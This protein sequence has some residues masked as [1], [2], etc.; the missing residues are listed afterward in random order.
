[1]KPKRSSR[2]KKSSPGPATS[3]MPRSQRAQ[4]DADSSDEEAEDASAIKQNT[5]TD[6]DEDELTAAPPPASSQ[7]VSSRLRRTVIVD[8]EDDEDGDSDDDQPIPT[9]SSRRQKV[10]PSEDKGGASDEDD[11]LPVAPSSVRRRRPEIV[12]L[13]SDSEDADISPMKKRKIAHRP[14]SSPS[15]SAPSA[16][17]ATR[18]LIGRGKQASSPVRRFKGHRTEKQKNME[19]LRRRR[20]GEKIEQLTESESEAEDGKRGLYDTDSAD[21]LQV[22][23]DFPDDEE[24]EEAQPE[25]QQEE[26]EESSSSKKKKS[27]KDKK[28]KKKKDNAPSASMAKPRESGDEGAESDLDDFVVED[29]DAPLGVPAGLLDIPLE[30][31]AQAHKPLKDQFPY[32][33]EW[34]VH[35]RINPAFDR[36]D[37]VYANAWR[38]LDDEV[39]ALATSKFTSSAWK[40]DFYRTLKARP[41][42]EAFEMDGGDGDLY[43]TCQACGR[44]GHPATFRVFFA[45]QP[46]DKTTLEDI[47]PDSSDSSD[48]DDNDND[49]QSVDTQG[50]VL[51]PASRE[52]VMGSVCKSNAETAHSLLHW[53]HALKVWVEENLEVGGH[54]TAARLQ[55]RERMKPKKRRHAA[56]RIVDAWEQDGVIRSLYRDFKGVLQ[57]ARDKSTT[58]RGGGRWR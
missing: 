42:M 36:H 2:K 20:A 19:L 30:F 10:I 5:D 34:L 32:V 50:N 44:S 23:E 43:D 21:D 57:A 56:N 52:W 29:D 12:E 48:D 58:G 39:R 33:V 9:S 54:M 49:R 7:S 38:K 24:E 31:T 51:P 37:P 55:E 15:S 53:K 14:A 28:K 40:V 17:P 35:R 16:K 8:D 46:Y 11:D 18:R 45:G 4:V 25:V 47:E 6:E 26:E 27:K 22:L 3:F 13:D 41:T 1:M